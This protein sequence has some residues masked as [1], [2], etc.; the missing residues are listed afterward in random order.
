MRHRHHNPRTRL[1]GHRRRQ[2]SG[3]D[4]NT[5]P[6]P[7]NVPHLN[8]IRPDNLVS[9]A[10]PVLGYMSN[11]QDITLPSSNH[12]WLSIR[13]LS[14]LNARQVLLLVI[15]CTSAGVLC[16]DHADSEVDLAHVCASFTLVQSQPPYRTIFALI[17][18]K[19]TD[20]RTL[21]MD[22]V[23]FFCFIGLAS[24]LRHEPAYSNGIGL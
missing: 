10:G 5:H 24:N 6:C 9:R 23:Y 14:G 11:K 20:A 13:L 21:R 2:G 4:N 18:S 8:S 16:L 12:H 22:S 17:D 15:Q 19:V 1:P 7:P 3:A